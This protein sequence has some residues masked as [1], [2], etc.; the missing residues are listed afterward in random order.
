MLVGPGTDD[1]DFKAVLEREAPTWAPQHRNKKTVEPSFDQS[2][3]RGICAIECHLGQY[4]PKS[5]GG[6]CQM[7]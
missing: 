5:L 6:T 1:K 4:G 2:K 3:A 7:V